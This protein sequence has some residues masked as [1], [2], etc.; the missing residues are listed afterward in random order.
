M[1]ISSSSTNL[2][3]LIISRVSVQKLIAEAKAIL[4][5]N[6]INGLASNNRLIIYKYIKRLKKKFLLPPALFLNNI[7]V[8]TDRGK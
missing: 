2:H 4:E 5:N 8:S 7:S 6:R 1:Q 3:K